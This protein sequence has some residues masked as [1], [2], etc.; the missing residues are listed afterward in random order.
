[1]LDEENGD[2]RV[3]NLYLQQTDLSPEGAYKFAKSLP[4]LLEYLDNPDGFMERM[5]SHNNNNNKAH[6]EK[7]RTVQGKEALRILPSADYAEEKTAGSDSLVDKFF[8]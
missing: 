8:S 2:P 3:R 4:Y 7:S 6:E 1:M 5:Q